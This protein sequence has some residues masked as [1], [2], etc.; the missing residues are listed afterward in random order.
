MPQTITALNKVPHAGITQALREASAKVGEDFDYLMETASRESSLNPKAKA[1]TSS[2]TGLFQFTEQTWLSVVKKY[3]AEHGLDAQ[4]ADIKKADGR[5][6]VPNAAD[7]KAILALRTDPKA[8]SLMAGEFTAENRRRLEANLERPV[9]EGELY[10]AHVMGAGGAAQLISAAE[11]NPAQRADKIFPE[12]AQANHGIFFEAN[13]RAR[14]VAQVVN[15]LT[16]RDEMPSPTEMAARLARVDVPAVPNVSVAALATPN[17][18]YEPEWRSATPTAN[19]SWSGSLKV[20]APGA[21]G[22][23]LAALGQNFN[24]L[25]PGMFAILASLDAPETN[26]R[27]HMQIPQPNILG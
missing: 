12:A 14:S 25:S 15:F 17:E 2:A 4:A 18:P 6:E 22:S 20:A 16:E 7:R 1:A 3:G 26:R 21:G 19:G 23:G 11:K 5:Y 9:S 24:M 13:G 27:N 10:A 8:A